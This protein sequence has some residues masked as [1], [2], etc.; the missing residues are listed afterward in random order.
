MN[1]FHFGV[2]VGIN[3]YPDI[4]H[5]RRAKGDAE[6]FAQWLANPNE[7]GLPTTRATG[8]L[9]DDGH[10]AT[11]VVDDA[12]VPDGAARENAV[13]VRRDVFVPLM[14]FRKAIEAHVA[15]HPEDWVH[16]RLYVYV[17]GHGI[18]PQARDAAILLAD[19]GP[20]WFGENIS[21]AQLLQFFMETQPFREVVVFADCCRERIPNAPLGGLPWELNSGNNGN[22]VSVLGCATYFGDLAYEPPVASGEV[23]DDLRGYFTKALLEG[24]RGE[25]ADAANAGVIDSTSLA[26]YVRQRVLELTKHKTPG[27]TP[28]M[29]A[30]PGNPIVFRGAQPAVANPSA[31]LV[32]ILFPGGFNGSVVMRDGADNILGT[33]TSSAAPVS[34][35][36]PNG[37]YSLI[38]VPPGVVF[39][40]DGL[41]RVWGS[42]R[43][44]QL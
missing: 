9:V 13:P 14:K 37:L 26:K 29:D 43:D 35:Y 41:F 15:L 25:A 36:L 12:K 17:S 20:G 22:V 5:L 4:K 39:Q 33:Y 1:R 30:D 23:A 21:C 16:T 18:A 38:S 31:H 32:R 27:Q 8:A 34:V 10:V 11:V 3:R 28:T 19:A 40:N 2:S 6:A 42:G 24:L 7:G 44:V